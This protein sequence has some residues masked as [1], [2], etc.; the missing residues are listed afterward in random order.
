MCYNSPM[1]TSLW[2]LDETII[3]ACKRMSFPVARFAIFIVYFWFGILK[4]LG[5][6]PANPLVADLLHTTM[7]FMSFDTF[8]VLFGVFEVLIGILFIF[9]KLDRISIVLF[10]LHM[11]TTFMVLIMLPTVSWSGMFVPTLEGQYVIKNIALIGL[12]IAIASHVRPIR[13]R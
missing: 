1:Q 7:P 10:A 3:A 5:L 11:V 6:S 2:R 13:S 4:V 12:V 9:P 8:I